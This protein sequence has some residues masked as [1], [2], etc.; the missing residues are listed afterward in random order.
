MNVFMK[1]ILIFCCLVGVVFLNACG[2]GGA[3]SAGTS[4]QVDP[5]THTVTV[6]SQSLFNSPQYIVQG[7]NGDF[8]VTDTDHVREIDAQG[9]LKNSITATAPNGIAAI[10]SSIYFTA[11]NS[12]AQSIYEFSSPTTSNITLGAYTFGGMVAIGTNLYATDSNSAHSLSVEAVATTNN[13]NWS[14]PTACVL[15]FQPVAIASDG[16]NLYVTL[17]NN[18]VMWYPITSSCGSGSITLS[19]NNSFTGFVSP[20][21]IAIS[22]GYAYVVNAG[23]HT[24][25]TGSISRINLSTG[26]V[27][28]IADN[29][30]VGIWP[31]GQVGFCNPFGITVDSG[32]NYLYVT[33]KTCSSAPNS[34]NQNTILKIKI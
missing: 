10:G 32:G 20:Q 22:G 1:K 24:G 11:G 12:N 33:N 4:N 7:S 18:D 23:D 29:N 6:V 9:T 15:P 5:I 25:T 2:G 3:S 21:G 31:A 30:S 26:A 34:A 16:T 13:H 17:T 28:V 27:T 14:N 8:F 19:T